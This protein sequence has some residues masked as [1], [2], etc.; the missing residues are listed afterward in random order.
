MFQRSLPG[1]YSS[2]HRGYA[3]KVRWQGTNCIKKTYRHDPAIDKG[4]GREKLARQVLGDKDWIIP[5]LDHG[6]NWILM[7]LLPQSCRLDRAIEQMDEE[8]KADVADQ[9]LTILFD[10]H[11]AGHVHGD[12]HAK[13]MFWRDSRI[14]VGDFEGFSP[15]RDGARPPF[16]KCYD[17]TR[18]REGIDIEPAPGERGVLRK[19]YFFDTD[20]RSMLGLDREKIV[21]H[22]RDGLARQLVGRGQAPYGSFS[23]PYLSLAPSQA[24]RDS[25]Q[26]LAELGV[27]KTAAKGASM[28]DLGCDVGGLLFEAQKFAPGRRVGVESDGAKVALA[29][30][31]AAFNGANG[32]SFIATD[33]LAAL[34]AGL[35]DP[36]DM[37]FC[38]LWSSPVDP[39]ELYDLLGRVTKRRLFLEG[40]EDTVTANLEPRLRDHDFGT[41]RQVGQGDGRPLFVAEKAQP[42]AAK[43]RRDA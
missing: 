17:L 41:V 27:G 35:A 12:F 3:R 24:Q 22:V 26:R 29:R 5:I 2:T 36:F 16:A 6:D 38:R 10:I 9:V 19:F 14:L 32:I 34:A 31:I 23:L 11:A 30:R 8:T 18:D 37:V 28:L 42:T 25:A 40:N 39:G 20:L 33:D 7:P 13:N 43:E 21:A 4:I 1:V 15:Y